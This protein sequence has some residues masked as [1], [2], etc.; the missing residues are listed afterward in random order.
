[1]KEETAGKGLKGPDMSLTVRGTIRQF[2][3]LSGFFAS[4]PLML[5]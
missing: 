1:M 5:V 2:Q 3:A 4:N